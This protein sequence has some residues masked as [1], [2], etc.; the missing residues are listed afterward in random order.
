MKKKILAT[1]VLGVI[2][3]FLFSIQVRAE[4]PIVTLNAKPMGDTLTDYEI[5]ITVYHKGKGYF[6]YLEG[7]I[8]L[9]NEEVVNVWQYSRKD[10][11]KDFPLTLKAK[12]KISPS[13]PS[14]VSAKAICSSEGESDRTSLQIIPGKSY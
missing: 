13:G 9:L 1:F 4:E 10:S 8:L 2:V 11:P 5:T 3:A 6:H 7:V 14:M 12:I